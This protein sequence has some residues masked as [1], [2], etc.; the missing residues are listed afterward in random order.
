VRRE[1][2]NDYLFD[3]I[4]PTCE[5]GCADLPAGQGKHHTMAEH[6]IENEQYRAAVKAIAAAT[7]VDTDAIKIA[8][9]EEAKIW[10]MSIKCDRRR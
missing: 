4:H 1:I 6:Y 5:S 9:G 7:G 10:P 3:T 8:L 2:V